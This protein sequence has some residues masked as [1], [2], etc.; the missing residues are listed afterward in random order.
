MNKTSVR[1]KEKN[2]QISVVD[3]GE[4]I[5]SKIHDKK[6]KIQK[7]ISFP[8]QNEVLKK[9]NT[10]ENNKPKKLMQDYL[11]LHLDTD[12]ANKWNLLECKRR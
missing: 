2:F 11:D 1:L 10:S 6:H 12:E 3:L 4:E 5:E 7:A 8:L 9:V